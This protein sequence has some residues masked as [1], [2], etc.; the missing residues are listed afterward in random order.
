MKKIVIFIIFFNFL[1]A[2]C[3]NER[4]SIAL[5]D[6]TSLKSAILAIAKECRY[7]VVYGDSMAREIVYNKKIT[8]VEIHKKSVNYIFDIL[9]S[10]NNLHYKIENDM[11]E[12]SYVL[13]KTFKVDYIDSTRIGNSNT[14]VTISGSSSSKSDSSNSGS[15]GANIVTEERFNFWQDLEENLQKIIKR[16]EDKDDSYE[17]SIVIDRKS[18]LVIASGTKRQ[19][20]RVKKYIDDMLESLRK[21]VVIDVQIISVALNKSH[22]VGIDWSKFSLD[23]GASSIWNSDYSKTKENGA[24]TTKDSKS[25]VIKQN[26]KLEMGGFFNFLKQYGE[27]KSLSNPKIVA[28][29]NQPTMISVGH[30]VNYLIKSST[31]TGGSTTTVSENQIPASLFVGVLLDI[32]AQIDDD[33]YVTLRINPSIS[34]FKYSEDAIKQVNARSLPPD[35]VTRRISSVVRVKDGDSIILG[36]LISSTNENRK[37]K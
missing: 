24:V 19:L 35:T 21:Q 13:T 33:N 12:I 3:I 27:A 16:P 5:P 26:T 30:N 28:I 22:T 4:L 2:K 37:I 32:T 29:N 6:N 31:T 8:P 1:F 15:T 17:A 14:D 23:F 7:S 20:D 34:E 18:G 9:I 11:L 10:K 25:L 36:G